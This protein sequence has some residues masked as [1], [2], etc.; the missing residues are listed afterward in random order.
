MEQPLPDS[1][2]RAGHGM[3]QRRGLEAPLV[4]DLDAIFQ[5]VFR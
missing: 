4:I 3:G 2:T 1:Y 5:A